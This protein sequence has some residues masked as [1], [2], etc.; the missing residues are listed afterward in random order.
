[1]VEP[2]TMMQLQALL[3]HLKLQEDTHTAAVT[4]PAILYFD[5]TQYHHQAVIPPPYHQKG[6]QP[7][8][9]PLETPF[10]ATYEIDEKIEELYQ[11]QQALSQAVAHAESIAEEIYPSSLS[12]LLS[13]P[14]PSNDDI[15]N[16]S[17]ISQTKEKNNNKNKKRKSMIS[18]RQH[19][20][21]L[22]QY[23]EY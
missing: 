3:S 19:G 4:P 2:P 20:P 17:F 5:D 14:S 10:Y 23:E 6:F 12:S 22:S 9:I 15:D 16:L 8:V 18:S 13:R 7:A 1:M 21:S 11:H